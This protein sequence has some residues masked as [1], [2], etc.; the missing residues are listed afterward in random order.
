MNALLP[1]DANNDDGG[2]EDALEPFLL[3]SVKDGKARTRNQDDEYWG[4][5]TPLPKTF[6]Q[7]SKLTTLNLRMNG[8]STLPDS[9]G[10]L[11]KL[12]KLTLDENQLSTL[13]DSFGALTALEKLWLDNN[14]LSTLP[15]SFGNL[16]ALTCLFLSE[17]R[18]STLPASF[19]RLTALKRFFFHENYVPHAVLAEQYKN[20]KQYAAT[21]KA[22]RTRIRLMS[23]ER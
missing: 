11:T 2:N 12:T 1:V 19:G 3:A 13:P 6:R 20:L 18:L 17:N 21:R 22:W 16:T 7:W 8:L 23:T 4:C 10:N 9:F 5:W 14:Q 15:G